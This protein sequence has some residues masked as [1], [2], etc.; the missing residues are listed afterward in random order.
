MRTSLREYFYS[1]RTIWNIIDLASSMLIIAFGVII[2]GDFRAGSAVVILAGFTSFLL[3]IKLL[4]FMRLFKPTSSFIRMII[5]M[6][7]DIWTFLL[8]FFISIFA[9]ANFYY[10]LDKGNKTRILEDWNSSYTG[11]V[12]YTYMQALGELGNDE[13]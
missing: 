2:L 3:W 5:E 10:I 12:I 6:F 4:Y 11:A 7:K 13:I 1:R 9:F 8:I